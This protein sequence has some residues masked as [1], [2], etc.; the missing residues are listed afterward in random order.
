MTTQCKRLS[1][2]VALWP[3]AELLLTHSGR[4]IEG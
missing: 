4:A 1:D 2:D 3:Q